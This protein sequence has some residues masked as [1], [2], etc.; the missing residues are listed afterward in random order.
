MATEAQRF[1]VCRLPV[2]NSVVDEI[3][4][5]YA[6]AGA[7]QSLVDTGLVGNEQRFQTVRLP[8]ANSIVDEIGD[9]Y[10]MAGIIRAIE[11]GGSVVEIFDTTWF[12]DPTWQVFELP[13]QNDGSLVAGMNTFMTNFVGQGTA[14]DIV[15]E[16]TVKATQD[17][18]PTICATQELSATVSV[19]QDGSPTIKVTL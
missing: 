18:S 16:V 2:A 8:F 11:T 6:I 3:G 15:T 7:M 9:R 4:D 17:P 1:Q 14:R 5:R 19:E 12:L 10:A 13:Q